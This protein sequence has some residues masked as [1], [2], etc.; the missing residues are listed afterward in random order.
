MNRK[1]LRAR[2][3]QK[4]SEQEAVIII[5]EVTKVKRIHAIL[6]IQVN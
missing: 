4:I 6:F 5:R 2:I 3:K 1:V